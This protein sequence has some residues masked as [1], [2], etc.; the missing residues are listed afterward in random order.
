MVQF[1]PFLC[2]DL[3][4]FPFFDPVQSQIHDPDPFQLLYLISQIPAHSADLPVQSLCQNDPE[5]FFSCP[6]YPAFARCRAKFHKRN[7]VCHTLQKCIR[8]RTVHGNKIFFFMHISRPHNFVDN[9]TVIRQQQQS[10]RLF[11]Q[12][13]DRIDPFRIMQEIN[14]IIFFPFFRRADN[15]RRLVKRDQYHFFFFLYRSSTETDLLSIRYL[16]PHPRGFSADG[17]ISCFNLAIC[18]S[19]GAYPCFT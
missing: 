7:T 18:F 19:S 5:L 13:P 6:F 3:S 12:T 17:Y 8:H 15:T 11:I 2:C 10:F 14:H 16:I 9:L 4:V 1:F